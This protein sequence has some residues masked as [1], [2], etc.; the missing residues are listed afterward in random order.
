MHTTTESNEVLNLIFKITNYNPMNLTVS[1]Y[2]KLTLLVSFITA[3][4]N[5][6]YHNK[7]IVAGLLQPHQVSKMVKLRSGLMQHTRA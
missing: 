5:H 3:E 7:G 4:D 2:F 1:P 6:L